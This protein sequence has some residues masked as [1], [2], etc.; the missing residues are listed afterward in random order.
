MSNEM[1]RRARE[2]EAEKRE[3]ARALLPLYHATGGIGWINDPNGFSLYRGEYHLFFQYYPYDVKWGPMHWGHLK[4]RDFI[5]WEQ[6]PAALAPDE[7]YDRDGCF[8]GSAVETPDGRHLLLYTGVRKVKRPDG[9]VDEFQTQCVAVGDG[10]DYVKSPLNP[11]IDAA[12]LPPDG[13]TRDFRDP[14]IWREGDAYRAVVADLLPDGGAILLFESTDALRWR[15]AGTL[16]AGHGR[17]GGMWECPDFFTLDGKAVLMHSAHD[18]RPEELE[19]HPGDG[20]VCHIGRFDRQSCRLEDEHVQT[21]DYGLDFY[22]PQTTETADGR[23]VMIGWMQS[24]AGSRVDPPRLPFFGQMTVPRELSIRGGRLCQWPVRELE[25][26]RGKRV[27]HRDVPVTEKRSLPGV[28]GRVLDLS[29]RVR[30]GEGGYRSFR[31]HAAEGEG[32]ET[33]LTLLPE[34][35]LLCTDRLYSGFIQDI[36]HTRRFPV[37]FRDGALSLRI[38]LDKYS[39][40]LFVG[41]GEQAASM[42]IYTPLSADGVSFSAEGCALLDVE[43]YELGMG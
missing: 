9:G 3:S 10:R 27:V 23:R 43:Q 40:E 32:Y 2:Y 17:L 42:T 31:I 14:K 22:A 4:T 19:F 11:V 21:V 8:S 41:Q 20:T 29:L 24:W 39:V 26:Y 28:R 6:L 34:E 18:M 1:L 38:L 37:N 5:R 35:G 12:L 36:A 16:A 33:V 30:P 25:W 7:D 13:D 15:R